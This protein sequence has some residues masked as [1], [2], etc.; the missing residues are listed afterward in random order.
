M[1]SRSAGE[2]DLMRESG[3]ITG[4]ALNKCLQNIKVGVSALDIDKIATEEIRRNKAQLAF[5]TVEN[6]GFATCI[7]FNEQ[8]V[9]GI[10]TN[11]TVSPGDVVSVDV[12]A[13]F[14]GW[15]TDAAWS[16]L[17]SG[18]GIGDPQRGGEQE[19]KKKFLQVGEQA[20]ADGISQAIE[21][22]KIGDI[23]AAIQK[24]VEGAHFSVV[25]SLV[26][27]GVG[28][29]LHEDPQVPGFGQAHTGPTL[30]KGMTLAIEVI[31]NYGK[32]EV[33]LEK[34]GWTVSS[35]DGLL[36]SLFEMSVIVGKERVEILTDFRERSSRKTLQSNGL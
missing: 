2:L 17:V 25:R 10:P 33:Q 34:D 4:L 20:L 15:F 26:G 28:E 18:Q 1:R 24:K 21:G 35:A 19:K 31:Y 27:H 5:P 3:R 32:P 6:Y 14:K 30:I 22:N 16:V 36:S 23:S 12:G 7:T 9:H 13:I 29:R 11:R 8:V